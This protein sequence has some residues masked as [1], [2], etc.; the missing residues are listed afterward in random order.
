MRP[1]HQHYSRSQYQNDSIHLLETVRVQLFVRANTAKVG[2]RID[3]GQ[4][5]DVVHDQTPKGPGSLRL[6]YLSKP[7]TL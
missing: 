1:Y 7:D 6:Y 4:V 2:E 5:S 3:H